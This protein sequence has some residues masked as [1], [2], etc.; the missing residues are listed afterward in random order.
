MPE[1]C[2][3]DTY[4][5][6]FCRKMCQKDRRNDT[7]HALLLSNRLT[8][9]AKML[10]TNVWSKA[11]VMTRGNLPK[12]Y[13]CENADSGHFQRQTVRCAGKTR[14]Y[15]AAEL[16]VSEFSFLSG[17]ATKI[18]V[19]YNCRKLFWFRLRFLTLGKHNILWSENF[20]KIF[21]IFRRKK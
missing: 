19:F 6:C 3:V 15:Q 21:G 14:T 4:R 20:W 2:P 11:Q 9:K 5:A 10:A 12:G 7:A 13:L 18:V 16:F 17:F 1:K 8:Q